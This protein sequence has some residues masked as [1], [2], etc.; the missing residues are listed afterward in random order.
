MPDIQK[1]IWI[2]VV[3]FDGEDFG[4]S[5]NLSSIKMGMRWGKKGEGSGV[6]GK[7]RGNNLESLCLYKLL[8]R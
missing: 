1:V 6:R 3:W 7:E 4:N 2:K 8:K 5:Q